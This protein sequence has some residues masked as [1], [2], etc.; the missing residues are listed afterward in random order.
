MLIVVNQ[1]IQKIH[2]WLIANGLKLNEKKIIYMLFG[3]PNKTYQFY[4]CVS[5]MP[6]LIKF[7]Y[8]TFLV[9]R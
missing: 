2:E 5:I 1:E 6:I 4:S 3:K 8:L 7:K 9:C